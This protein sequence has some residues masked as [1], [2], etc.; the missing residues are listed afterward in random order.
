MKNNSTQ[1]GFYLL[2]DNTDAFIARFALA[3]M[4]EK[5]LDI[6]YYIMHN[7]ASGQYL[8]YA[9]LS[10]ANRGVRVRILVDDI[11][12]SGRDQRLKTFSQHENIEIRIFNPLASRDWFR[13][14]EL[15]IN[16][17]RAGR[18]MHNKAFVADNSAAIIGGRNIGDEYFDARPNLNFVD[19]DMLSIGPIVSDITKSFNDYWNSRWATA[20]EKLSKRK[21]VQT[22][23][24]S[25]QR[26]LKD[27]WFRIKNTAYFKSIQNAE[28]TKN[29]I[30]KKIA[31][32]WADA[33]LFYDCPNKI[34]S[35]ASGTTTHFGPQVLPYFEQSKKELLLASP[36]FVPGTSGTKWFTDK[37]EQG[38]QI[39]ILTNSLAATDVIAV[40]AGY[41]KY[42]KMLLEKNISLF[43]LKPTAHASIF[44]KHKKR[45]HHS[46][47]SLH[48]KYM[49]VDRQY[50]FV[51]SANLDPRSNRL[52]TEIGIMVDSKE[53]A[54]QAVLLFNR[55]IAAENSYQIKLSAKNG[56]LRWHTQEHHQ[57]KIYRTEPDARL[58]RKLAV[59]FIR[60]LPIEN[61]L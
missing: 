36:Y 59:F 45:Q 10:A 61:L 40:H 1:S 5:T 41:E 7:D 49:I 58:L 12:L 15:I 51:G 13:N 21:V 46:Q 4:A 14:I 8:Y 9:I 35:H 19:L 34:S 39:K 18:R 43:E 28:L 56:K 3:T 50:V 60:L 42:R 57:E 27:K 24:L 17:N 48:A 55:T 32:I 11:N 22:Q 29:I 6:Q 53:L 37:S 31:F 2:S 30:Q 44:N 16:L 25:M 33:E 23:L 52:N 20:I 38:V 47:A 26:K 54:E